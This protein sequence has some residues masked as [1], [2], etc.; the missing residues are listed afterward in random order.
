LIAKA[1]Q[2][3]ILF[4]N[5]CFTGIF[6]EFSYRLK[7]QSLRE[8]AS[9]ND[10][11]DILHSIYLFNHDKIMVSNDKIFNSILPNINLMSVEDYK[12]LI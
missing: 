9:K 4:K 1:L 6:A 2:N 12:E 10:W 11:L 3:E 8:S 7:K 5:K